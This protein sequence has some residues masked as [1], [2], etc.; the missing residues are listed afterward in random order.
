VLAQRTPAKG[1]KIPAKNYVPLTQVSL[2]TFV[3]RLLAGAYSG[4]VKWA[5]S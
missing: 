5:R 3:L 2:R 4:N 1:P